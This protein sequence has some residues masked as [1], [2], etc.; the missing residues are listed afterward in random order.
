MNK[1]LEEWEQQ[2]YDYAKKS[3]GLIK[4]NSGIIYFQSHILPIVKAL[5]V[6]TS[7]KE[8]IIAAY[9]HDLIEDTDI[10]Y[11]DLQEQFGTKVADYVLEVT[12]EGGKNHLPNLHTPSAI[13]LK[14]IDRASNISRM[15]PW[16]SKRREYY[17]NKCKF[18]KPDGVVK[19]VKP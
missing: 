9:M 13:T 11:E 19:Y 16:S 12:E 2:A 15:E 18:W 10:T 7:E 1:K 14:L 6:F 5:K 3:Y 8:I 17:I 4:D